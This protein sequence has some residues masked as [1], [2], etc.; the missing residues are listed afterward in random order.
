MEMSVFCTAIP[1]SQ[2]VQ[3]SVFWIN[4]SLTKSVTANPCLQ[5]AENQNTVLVD[6]VD[7]SHQYVPEGK[8]NN[9]FN[10]K[11]LGKRVERSQIFFCDHVKQDQEVE[12]NCY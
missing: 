6:L 8:E 3:E 11:E 5:H 9:G 7:V 2:A 1:I 4:S 12:G 10:T